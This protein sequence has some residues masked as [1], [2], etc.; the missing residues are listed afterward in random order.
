VHTVVVTAANIADVTQTATLLRG[1]ETQ[2]HADAGYTG[3]EKHPE[4]VAPDRRIDWQIAAKRGVIKALAEEAKKD[5][6][7]AV[8]KT[9]AACARSSDTP[10]TS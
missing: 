4:I 8:E 6:L 2:V 3:E 1:A 9:K 5:A 10:S 7:K